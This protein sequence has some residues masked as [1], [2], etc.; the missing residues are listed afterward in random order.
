ML[1][2]ISR[3]EGDVLKTSASLLSPFN[4]KFSSRFLT[5]DENWH[6]HFDSCKIMSSNET[7]LLGHTFTPLLIRVD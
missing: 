2:L 7:G 4:G 3:S 1:S 5:V 6:H